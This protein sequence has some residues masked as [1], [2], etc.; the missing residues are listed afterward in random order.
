M[1]VIPNF[2]FDRNFDGE[3]NAI[4]LFGAESLRF[5]LSEFEEYLLYDGEEILKRQSV[6]RDIYT[7]PTLLDGFEKLLTMC[8]DVKSVFTKNGELGSTEGVV[9]SLLELHNF[10]SAVDF[11]ANELFAPIPEGTALSETLSDMRERFAA[12]AATQGYISVREWLNSLDI[13]LKNIRSVTLGVNLNAQLDI[14]EV[15]VVSFNEQPYVSGG[16]LETV[17]RDKSVPREYTCIATLGTKESGKLLGKGSIA[18]NR[19]FFGAMNTLFRGSARALKRYITESLKEEVMALISLTEDIAFL[20]KSARYMQRLRSSGLKLTFPRV[21]ENTAIRGLAN[22]NLTDK[23]KASQIVVSDAAFDM[24]RRIYILTGPNSGGKSVYLAALG[25]AQ[26]MFQ[27]GLP[28]CAE[29]A[30]IKPCGEIIVLFVKEIMKSTESRLENEVLRLRAALDVVTDSSLILLDEMFSSTSAYDG[31]LLAKSLVKYL[32]KRRCC[33]IYATH[34]HELAEWVRGLPKAPIQLLS[35]ESRDGHRTY[36]IV[37]G[38]ECAVDSSLA[39]DIVIE[40]G[41]GFLFE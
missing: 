31:V 27:L 40:N 30:H 32:E 20:V 7:Y 10:C 12:F 41:L 25:I 17:L 18:V 24:S 3:R 4:R 11:T 26:L 15:G 1:T 8:E 34:F 14:A 9:Y 28:I 19:E 16:F 22:P 35:A 23:C 2:L 5:G 29:S 33:A 13:N 36:R 38:D 39:R 21:S 37:P 6:F